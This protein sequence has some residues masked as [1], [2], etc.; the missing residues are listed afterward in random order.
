MILDCKD[1]PPAVIYTLTIID[2]PDSATIGE[3]HT[4]VL[5]RSL[6]LTPFGHYEIEVAAPGYITQIFTIEFTSN[7]Q[8]EDVCL[9]PI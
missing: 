8:T 5:P 6:V 2:S 7:G 9:D 1:N 3:S 4:G